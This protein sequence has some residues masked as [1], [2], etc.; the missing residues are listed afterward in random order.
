[1]GAGSA[2]PWKRQSDTLPEME[3]SPG[4]DSTPAAVPTRPPVW[5]AIGL[6]AG[7]VAFVAVVYWWATRPEVPALTAGYSA[8]IGERSCRECHPGETAAHSRSGHSQTLRRAGITSEAR[9][10]DG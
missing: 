10:L 5:E 4:S 8:Y 1:M 7:L 3:S 6:C 9:K 2:A